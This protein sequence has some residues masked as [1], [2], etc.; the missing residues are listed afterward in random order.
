MCFTITTPEQIA[1]K[2]IPCWKV[3]DKLT[4]VYSSYYYNS[5]YRIGETYTTK[6]L[7]FSDFYQPATKKSAKQINQGRHSYSTLELAKLQYSY[8]SAENV[9]IVKCIIP[10]GASYYYNRDDRQYVS[11]AIKLIKEIRS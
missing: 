10:K 6:K 9:R 1:K 3:L 2:D 11:S 5:K 4:G 8:C 7:G